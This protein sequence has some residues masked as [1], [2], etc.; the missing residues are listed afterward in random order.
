MPVS[1]ECAA[2]LL[3]FRYPSNNNNNDNDND[4]RDD[5]DYDHDYKCPGGNCSLGESSGF[6]QEAAATRS[7]WYGSS[8]N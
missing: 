4:N 2:T 7:Q 1:T 6:H 8:A 5:D 3:S